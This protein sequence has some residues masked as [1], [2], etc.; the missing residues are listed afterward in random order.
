M[1]KAVYD[2][3]KL[4]RRSSFLPALL[5]VLFAALVLGGGGFYAMTLTGPLGEQGDSDSREAPINDDQDEAPYLRGAGAA[6]GLFHHIFKSK[7]LGLS[8]ALS[9]RESPSIMVKEAKDHKGPVRAGDLVVKVA[10][11]DV[12]NLGLKELL[13]EIGKHYLPLEITF[14]R[15]NGI[16]AGIL[17]GGGGKE[18]ELAEEKEA[19][20]AASDGEEK[21]AAAE[22]AAQATAD[23]A[24][25]ARA[26]AEA[27][28]IGTAVPSEESRPKK[29]KHKKAKLPET[30]AGAGAGAAG[31]GAGA[32]AAGAGAAGAA[33]DGADGA[34]AGGVIK[35]TFTKKHLGIKIHKASGAAVVTKVEDEDLKGV[36][37]EGD[38]LLTVVGLDVTKM[39]LK[40]IGA[41]LKKQTP[42]FAATF[43]RPRSKLGHDEE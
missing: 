33:A 15:P 1:P 27:A 10:G 43:T 14:K 22:A 29:F 12:T 2:G 32:G 38:V 37:Q 36:V 8:L 40:V 34:G 30:G 41:L 5:K 19:N 18:Q 17:G 25:T 9:G 26:A 28:A 21:E 13:V 42:P 11:N 35:H 20:M 3:D 24:G 31:A 6:K 39:S 23:A 4:K 7:P 16:V